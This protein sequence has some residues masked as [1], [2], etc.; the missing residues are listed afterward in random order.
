M[1]IIKKAIESGVTEEQLII[2][3]KELFNSREVEISD[4]FDV[5]IADPQA[6]HW[7]SENENQKKVLRDWVVSMFKIE[8]P[9]RFK[10]KTDSCCEIFKAA[11]IEVAKELAESWL[12][13]CGDYGEKPCYVDA[14]VVE[15]DE[16]EV[17]IDYPEFIEAEWEGRIEIPKCEHTDG[18]DWQEPYVVVGGCKENPGVYGISGARIVSTSV[19]SR[20][21]MYRV[22]TSASILG[23]YPK[24][25]ESYE[26]RDADEVS[27]EWVNSLEN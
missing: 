16:D 11:D 7:I 9:R 10:V 18:H 22:H 24:E 21:A 4:D 15:I 25:P 20:C 14:A 3:I 26:Y 5:Y 8:S 13:E 1:N 19:C 23:S 27:L 6:G 17:E 2:S 12:L